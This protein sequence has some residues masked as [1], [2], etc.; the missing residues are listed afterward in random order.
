MLV[1]V[2][3][4]LSCCEC[5]ESMGT[6][7]QLPLIIIQTAID[8]HHRRTEHWGLAVV[9]N[10]ALSH[11]RVFELKGNMDTFSYD[12]Y[13]D[14][15]ASSAW[16]FRGGVHVGNIEAS[17]LADLEHWLKSVA[18]RHH[19]RLWDCQNWVM[20][21]LRELQMDKRCEVFDSCDEISLRKEMAEE[22]ERDEL[23]EDLLHERLRDKLKK[24]MI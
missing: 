15:S 5:S 17:N 11:F 20:E 23:G 3:A 14:Q 8:G 2:P 12:V 10:I 24:N 4:A 6:D 18:I 19:D 7:K 21:A 22:K 13:D 9:T 1:V 16:N